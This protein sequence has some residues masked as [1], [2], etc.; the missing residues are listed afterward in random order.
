MKNKS[1]FLMGAI[2]IA[3]AFQLAAFAASRDGNLATVRQMLDTEASIKLEGALACNM[4]T[5]N[6]GQPCVLQ[7]MEKSGKTIRLNNSQQAM[8]LFH[9]GTKNVAIE[10]KMG[11]DNTLQIE[12]IQAI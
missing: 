4:G 7:L 11:D 3:S 2:V 5:E 1:L 9:S 6:T 12:N 10:G 8:K